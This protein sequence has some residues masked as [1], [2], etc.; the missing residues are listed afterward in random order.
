[1]IYGFVDQDV[2][3]VDGPIKW[4][5]HLRS[6]DDY[7]LLGTF[8]DFGVGED[9]AVLYDVGATGNRWVEYR[10]PV[11]NGI[12]EESLFE[13]WIHVDQVDPSFNGDERFGTQGWSY[14]DGREYA[15]PQGLAAAG[16]RWGQAFNPA[17]R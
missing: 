17:G 6:G 1:M 9:I 5:I 3:E 4:W 14:L 10:V 12:A 11:K 16:T 2:P 13:M 8:D 7:E 15:S